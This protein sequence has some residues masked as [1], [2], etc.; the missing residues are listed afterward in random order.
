MQSNTLNPI[1]AGVTSE[2]V[3]M[4]SLGADVPLTSE[5]TAEAEEVLAALPEGKTIRDFVKA[6]EQIPSLR[7]LALAVGRSFL[8]DGE[9]ARLYDRECGEQV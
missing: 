5:Q 4:L 8:A 2:V 9:Y 1:D 6:A 7:K 3:S